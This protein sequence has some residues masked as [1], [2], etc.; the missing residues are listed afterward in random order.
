MQI[1]SDKILTL[2]MGSPLLYILFDFQWLRMDVRWA[3]LGVQE[4]PHVKADAGIEL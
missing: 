3:W 4:K 2:M 1:S